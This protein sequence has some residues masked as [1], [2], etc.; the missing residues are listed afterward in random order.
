VR[1]GDSGF[2][3]EKK[4]TATSR[5]DDVM[6]QRRIALCGAA[7]ALAALPGLAGASGFQ[8]NERSAKALG[9]SLAGSVSAG[10]DVSFA[11]FNPAV[12][13][14]VGRM[15]VA[16]NVSV[17][18]PSS[19]GT[20]ETGPARG[21]D[22]DSGQGAAIPGFAGGVRVHERVVIGLTVHAPFGLVTDH[23]P[24]FPGAA[25]GTTSDLRTVQV[26]PTVAV[27]LTDTLSV[28]AAL[29]VLHADVRLKSAVTQLDGDDIALG[30]SAGAHWEP[31]PG[32]R[33][34]V[35]YHSGFD[36]ETE[37]RQRNLL[38][39][40]VTAPLSAEASL[41]GLFQAG[42]TQRVTEDLTLMGEV[43]YITWEEFDT[44]EFSSPELA[45]TPFADFEEEQNYEDAMF[46]AIGAEYALDDALTLRGG[47]AYDETPTT[48]AFRTVRVPDGDRLW[49]SVGA[50]YDVTESLTLDFAYNY[51]HVLSDPVVTLRSGAAAGTRIGYEGHV[52]IVSLGAAFRF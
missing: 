51:L 10:S 28:G 36:L 1:P 41:P 7:A 23:P 34:G 37:G 47:L 35:A 39:G 48:D 45:G 17:V 24:D 20:I 21:Y 5:E 3:E 14:R 9:A 33:L 30:V 12:L 42:V 22:F 44:L 19:D 38:L 49:A 11:G 40:G 25:D 18:A 27:E 4:M 31:V 8:L 2:L 6:G 15:E 46:G 16:G 13:S 52:H 32:T 26:S 50:S 29:D 43:R